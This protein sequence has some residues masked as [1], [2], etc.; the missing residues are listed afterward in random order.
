M[1]HSVNV[2]NVSEKSAKLKREGGFW[3]KARFTEVGVSYLQ[4]LYEL[5]IFYELF[6]VRMS[7]G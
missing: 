4:M 3:K 7:V 2:A 6:L 5:D 1:L